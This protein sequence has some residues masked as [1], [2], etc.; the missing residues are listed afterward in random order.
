MGIRGSELRDDEKSD[1]GDRRK[2]LSLTV[3][4][5]MWENVT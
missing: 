3:R 2:W 5:E 1:V 4:K